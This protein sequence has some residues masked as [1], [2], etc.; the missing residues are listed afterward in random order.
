MAE[1]EQPLKRRS[2]T[3]STN[4]YYSNLTSSLNKRPMGIICEEETRKKNGVKKAVKPNFNKTYLNV[5]SKINTGVKKTQIV[6]TS[7]QSN[8]LTAKK[9]D[10]LYGRVSG[11]LVA[12]FLT[13]KLS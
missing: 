5:P 7:R 4:V 2:T 8:D 6:V 1:I 11:E 9:R 3:T 12:K 13:Q 10:E